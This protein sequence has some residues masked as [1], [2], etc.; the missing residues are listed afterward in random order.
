MALLANCMN[1]MWIH[2]HAKPFHSHALL[3]ICPT[4]KTT[5]SSIPAHQMVSICSTSTLPKV[6]SFMT[7]LTVTLLAM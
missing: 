2:S 3:D 7:I 5:S 1:T 6:F 4:L